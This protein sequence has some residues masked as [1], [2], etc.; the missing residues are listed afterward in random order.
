MQI[1]L[2][3]VLWLVFWL[4]IPIIVHLLFGSS[5][6]PLVSL[7]AVVSFVGGALLAAWLTGLFKDEGSK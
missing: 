3:L 5:E 7:A 2:F 4:S 6:Y 1:A